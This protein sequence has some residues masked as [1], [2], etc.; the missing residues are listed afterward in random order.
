[1]NELRECVAVSLADANRA[2]TALRAARLLDA[3]RPRKI[4]GEL[5]IP[6]LNAEAAAGLLKSAGVVARPCRAEFEMRRRPLRLSDEDLGV[7]GFLVVGDII[8]LNY[9]SKLGFQTYVDA[10]SKLAEIY[11]RAKSIFLKLGTTG[12]LRLPQLVLLYGAGETLT[13]VKESGLRFR[14]DVAKTY[15]NPR[16]SGERQRIASLVN[17]NERVLD[18][19]CGVA[20]FSIAVASRSTATVVANDL[21]PYAAALA[22]ANVALNAKLLKGRVVVLRS[23]ARALP[24]VVEGRFDRI[25]MNNPTSSTEFLDVAC[26]L[27]SRQSA[28]LHVYYL[29]QTQDEAIVNIVEAASRSCAD[30]NVEFSRKVIEYSPSKS[31]FVADLSCKGA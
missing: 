6:V 10:V 29:A 5:A 19:F 4:D 17:S 12:E 13:V 30:V 18:M 9:S 20:P 28:T 24:N 16:L 2:L 15:F 1:M 25:I 22:E 27:A 8:L 26:K 31:I 23:D 3:W 7:S 14:V 21:N 11:P